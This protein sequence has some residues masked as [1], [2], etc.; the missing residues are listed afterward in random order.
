MSFNR[1]YMLTSDKEIIIALITSTGLMLF[2]AGIIIAAIIKYQSRSRKYL[3]EMSNLK[4]RYQEEAIKA[5]IEKED[6]T[7]TRIS[8]EIH[9]N[10]GQILSL[11]KLNLNTLDLENCP[12]PIKDKVLT[13]KEL[14]GKAINDLRHLS[15]SLNSL[16]L[17]HG[18]LSESLS[19]ELD[20]INRTGAFITNLSVDGEEKPF[21]PQKQLIIFRIAQEALNNIIKHANAFHIGITLNYGPEILNLIIKDDGVGFN[22]IMPDGAERQK[23][24]TGLVNIY[25]RA[26][27]IGGSVR[28]FSE[29]GLGTS[30]DIK[31][32]VNPSD[33]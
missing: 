14:V 2:L 23:T 5:Q 26:E 18:Y 12:P 9:D 7:L 21:N 20:I 22:N 24:G 32:P 17:S 29:K 30:I 6:Q 1:I 25:N 28:I 15:K 10:I 3:Q 33:Y 19:G 8:Q 31:I 11:V 13:T 4:I 16:H 27:L